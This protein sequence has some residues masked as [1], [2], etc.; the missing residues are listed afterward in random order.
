MDI[1]RVKQHAQVMLGALLI[2]GA[3]NV[4]LLLLIAS[5]INCSQR[6]A[7][8]VPQLKPVDFV[9]IAKKAEPPKPAAP[10][11]Q[12]KVVEETPP[13]PP[14]KEKPK[15]KLKPR[16]APEPKA[17]KPAPPKIDKVA[18][19]KLD[20]PLN[21]SGA[22]IDSVPGL[23]SRLTAP[24]DKWDVKQKPAEGPKDI[25]LSSRLVAVSRVMPVYPWKA[26]S[27]RTEGWV[28]LEVV[29]DTGGNVARVTVLEDQPKGVFADA[30]I[31]AIGQWRFQPAYRDGQPVEQRAIQMLEFRLR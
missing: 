2:A 11:E 14:P 24:P 26:K 6:P 18:A 17:A 27:L 10:P 31:K 12:A 19:P 28:K 22:A 9:R 25:P 16:K 4:V 23:D 5:L 3:V 15:P 7:L 8:P 21:G 30:A 13:P 29:V 20:I 1:A